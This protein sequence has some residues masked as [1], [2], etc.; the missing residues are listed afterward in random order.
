MLDK[1]QLAERKDAMN[2]GTQ[3]LKERW[4][5]QWELFFNM[6]MDVPNE[7]EASG[8]LVASVFVAAIAD[9]RWVC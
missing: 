5:S 3:V 2:N 8:S 6:V 1:F 7:R 4:S 9:T